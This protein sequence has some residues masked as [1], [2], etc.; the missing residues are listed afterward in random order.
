VQA[1]PGGRLAM[2]NFSLRGLI[3]FAYGVRDFQLVGLPAWADLVHYDV[4]AKTEGDFSVSQMEGPMLQA[5]LEDR[6]QLRVHREIRQMAVYE[7]SVAKS[8]LKMKA[9]Q[10]GACVPYDAD[11][12][13]PVVHLSGAGGMP[14]FCGYPTNRATGSNRTLD[15]A[16]VSATVLIANLSRLAVD[17]SIIDKTGLDVG[18]DVHLEWAADALADDAGGTSIFTALQEQL[19]LKLE[20]A[21]GPVEVLVI[22]S[23]ERA[24][25]N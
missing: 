19:G 7:L 12:P 9:T 13:P 4:Q 14:V 8:G 11:A 23:V 21:K 2:E 1:L 25:A 24:S 20:A 3:L 6:L 18:Y 10:Q 17:R 16:G 22:D 5:L 15:G